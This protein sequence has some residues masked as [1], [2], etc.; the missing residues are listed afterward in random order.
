MLDLKCYGISSTTLHS[1]V[2]VY[3]NLFKAYYS[4]LVKAKATG[5]SVLVQIGSSPVGQACI[6]VCLQVGCDLFVTVE[7]KHHIAPLLNVF[8]Q[9]RYFVFSFDHDF[10]V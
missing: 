8:P 2:M 3:T 7:S 9:V 10:N 6:A 5:K 4:I 1:V